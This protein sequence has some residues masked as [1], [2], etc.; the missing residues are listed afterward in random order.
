MVKLCLRQAARL[1]VSTT[2]VSPS[3]E[4]LRNLIKQY[5]G[6]VL[7]ENSTAISSAGATIWAEA[8]ENMGAIKF[9]RQDRNGAM[10][11]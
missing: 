3:H 2:E 1:P 8:L 5:A 11:T 10:Y 6:G 4:R 9:W 7:S